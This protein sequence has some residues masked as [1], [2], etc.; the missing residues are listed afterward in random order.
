MDFPTE[1]V[2]PFAW[3]C[4]LRR[5]LRTTRSGSRGR[6]GE[7][8]R[9][10]ERSLKR[11]A[12][13]SFGPRG[14]LASLQTGSRTGAIHSG[15]TLERAPSWYLH[16]MSEARDLDDLAA[17]VSRAL[18][19]SQEVRAAYL[20]GSQAAGGA[21]MESDID[22]GVLFDSPPEP[23]DIVR[24]QRRLEEVLGKAVDVVDV[25]S[26][27]AFLALDIIKGRR[28]LC[29]DE[30]ACDEFELYVLRRAGDLEPYER[31]RRAMLLGGGPR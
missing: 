20:F 29:R 23:S 9:R 2:A 30:V 13:R 10:R 7:R 19:G 18:G 17:A 8:N 27:G 21:T 22:V 25:G 14:E 4:R 28:V 3:G 11:W 26:A 1:P 15:C 5:R 6:E 12:W 24:L 16:V 31:E